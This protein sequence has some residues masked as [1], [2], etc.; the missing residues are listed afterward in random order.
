MDRRF[1]S[2]I[3]PGLATGAVVESPVTNRE[4]QNI[5]AARSLETNTSSELNFGERL[6]QNAYG[7]SLILIE[8]IL[9][10][11]FTFLKQFHKI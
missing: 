5:S 6:S 9:N 4:Q 1:P 10:S 3:F 2:L 8:K 7:D 11:Y